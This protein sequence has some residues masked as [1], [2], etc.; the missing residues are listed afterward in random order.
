MSLLSLELQSENYR[1]HGL[2]FSGM[3]VAGF[4][5]CA[6]AVGPHVCSLEGL[7]FA[8]V[9]V[10]AFVICLILLV[11]GSY[12]ALSRFPTNNNFITMCSAA[13]PSGFPCKDFF[14]LDVDFL[15]RGSPETFLKYC[16]DE[17]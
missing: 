1:S 10:N 4:L 6:N 9:A 15:G 13:L 8:D 11:I 14:N 2:I 5:L 16:G 12:R 7:G 17:L 3:L